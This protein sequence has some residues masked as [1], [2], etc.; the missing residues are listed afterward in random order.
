MEDVNRYEW[1]PKT[2]YEPAQLIDFY[3]KMINDHPLIEFIEDCFAD[4]D[5]Q[6]YKKCIEKFATNQ[7]GV[8]I[9]INGLFESDIER[10]KLFT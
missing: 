6:G 8:Q 3:E 9:G 7:P 2:Q 1:E 5:I 4:R 10:I